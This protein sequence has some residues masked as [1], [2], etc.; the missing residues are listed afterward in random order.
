MRYLTGQAGLT[1]LSGYAFQGFPE[2]SLETQ[3][4]SAKCFMPNHHY[5]LE[6]ITCVYL[7]C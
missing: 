7:G 6:T 3:S 2:E 1:G 5:G 4:P